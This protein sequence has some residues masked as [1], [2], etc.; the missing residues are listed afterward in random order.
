[1]KKYQYRAIHV[2]VATVWGKPTKCELCDTKKAKRYEWSNKNHKY[3]LIKKEWQQ[4]C[5]KCH[6][7]WDAKKFGK[8]A[9]NK[10]VKG[11]KRWHNC[12]GLNQGVP[13][14]IGK[15]KEE[16]PQLSNSG[17][18]KGNTPWNKGLHGVQQMA[19]RENSPHWKG[20]KGGENALIRKSVDYK[21]WREAVFKRDNFTCKDC[22]TRGYLE[23]HHIKPFAWFPE[24]RFAID[25]GVTLCITCHAKVDKV[26]A[27]TLNRK[28]FQD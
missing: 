18:K 22:K 25:N 2:A 17:A 24:L 3:N 5:S 28:L 11:L 23:A 13:W 6:G 27:R 14:N 8:R 4:L 15:T 26:R 7:A 10:G 12:K 1:M 16:Y 19:K 20:G 9:W 21:L